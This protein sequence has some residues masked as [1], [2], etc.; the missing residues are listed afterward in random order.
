VSEHTE[1]RR[2][3]LTRAE[4][5]RSLQPLRRHYDCQVHPGEREITITDG[6]RRVSIVLG[7]ESL[8]RQGAL[9]LPT[10]DVQ[11]TFHGYDDAAL[12]EFHYLFDLSFRRGG[13]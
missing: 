11:L 9:A 4:F 10:L 6:P 7:T 2:M 3:T 8:R 13:G 12:A 5:L 1:Q